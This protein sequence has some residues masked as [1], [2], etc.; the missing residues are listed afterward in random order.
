[1]T[2]RNLAFSRTEIHLLTPPCKNKSML[3]TAFSLKTDRLLIPCCSV[4]WGYF[5][6]L[7]G[8]LSSLIIPILQ[9]QTPCLHNPEGNLRVFLKQPKFSPLESEECAPPP[10]VKGR[11]D[12]ELQCL[13]IRDLSLSPAT[14]QGSPKLTT[15]LPSLPDCS[16]PVQNLVPVPRSC[17]SARRIH[18]GPVL[19]PLRRNRITV[20]M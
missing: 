8:L 5:A 13:Q 7:V 11:I 19:L 1:M 4:Y 10:S 12:K 6:G 16:G 18:R 9:G 3:K 15:P 14:T 17:G 2:G 20:K